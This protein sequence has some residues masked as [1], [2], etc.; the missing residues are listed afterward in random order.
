VR[1][2]FLYF[3]LSIVHTPC[4]FV[5]HTVSWLLA[6]RIFPTLVLGHVLFAKTTKNRPVLLEHWAWGKIKTDI[7]RLS[8]G[9]QV[10]TKAEH[11]RGKENSASRQGS[12][13]DDYIPGSNCIN[14]RPPYDQIANVNLIFK[15]CLFNA[16]NFVKTCSISCR[17][18]TQPWR[19]TFTATAQVSKEYYFKSHFWMT[20]N[21][22]W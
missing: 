11:W 5:Q 22:H 7:A 19:L 15:P 1:H 2:H 4:M 16:T 10:E 18:T 21:C 13:L 12:C 6:P 9:R 20:Y 3:I 17:S 14:F 8:Q